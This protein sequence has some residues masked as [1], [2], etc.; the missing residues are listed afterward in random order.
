MAGEARNIKVQ[1]DKVEKVFNGRSGEMVA[2]NGVSLDITDKHYDQKY[3]DMQDRLYA[4]YDDIEFVENEIEAQ[5]KQ[6][7]VIKEQR[8]KG[9]NIYQ[10]LALYDIMYKNFTDAE[11][12]QFLNQFLESVEIFKEQQP[13]GQILKSITFKFPV[14]YDGENIT[15]ICW[16]GITEL[17]TVCLMSRN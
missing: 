7:S 17:E 8:I 16:D 9:E 13:S 1:I 15:E 2:L 14:F 6:I 11:K 10:F 12:K 3:Q 5:K 4:F